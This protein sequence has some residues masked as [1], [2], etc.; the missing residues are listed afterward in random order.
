MHQQEFDGEGLD[1]ENPERE[2]F[3]TSR[4]NGD[5][6]DPI[7]TAMTQI[8]VAESIAEESL[9]RY[10]IQ[11]IPTHFAF[12]LAEISPPSAEDLDRLSYEDAAKVVNEYTMTVFGFYHPL[13]S[14][15]I[16][17][18]ERV[19]ETADIIKAVINYSPRRRRSSSPR[20][21]SKKKITSPP[22]K[23]KK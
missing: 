19:E 3:D 12:P 11:A 23:K 8:G 20:I 4:P 15:Y 5:E 6:D 10:T 14:D 13:L 2:E 16:P 17:D 9:A 7:E 1:Y 22:R 18:A 21:R